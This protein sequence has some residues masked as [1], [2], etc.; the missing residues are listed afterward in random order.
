MM[1][2]MTGVI[3]KGPDVARATQIGSPPLVDPDPIA[4]TDVVKQ[5]TVAAM[6]GG[7]KAVGVSIVKP[8]QPGDAGPAADASSAVQPPFGKAPAETAPAAAESNELKPNVPANSNEL[9]PSTSDQTLP[10][11][12]QV[13]EI[14]QGESSSRDTA[15]SNDDSA[16]ASDQ[17][18]SSSRKKKKKGLR[19][20]VPF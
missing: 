4:A 10:P 13:N 19:K 6:G 11:P 14:Q 15:K 5:E 16:P 9:V 2:R 18:L 3:K 7:E 8:D 20:I 12:T 1:Q 17:D